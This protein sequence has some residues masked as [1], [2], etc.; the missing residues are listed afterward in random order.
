MILPCVGWKLQELEELVSKTTFCDLLIWRSAA[1]IAP[2]LDI[3]P[4]PV[5]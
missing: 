1:G 2:V 5:S 3:A 4:M